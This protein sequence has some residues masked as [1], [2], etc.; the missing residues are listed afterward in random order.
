MNLTIRGC[1]TLQRAHHCR[2]NCNHS[3]S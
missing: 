2:A 3:I 1:S